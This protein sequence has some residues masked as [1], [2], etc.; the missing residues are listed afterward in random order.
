MEQGTVAA[1]GQ[2]P[3]DKVTSNWLLYRKVHSENFSYLTEEVLFL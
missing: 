3:P 1:N 2:K